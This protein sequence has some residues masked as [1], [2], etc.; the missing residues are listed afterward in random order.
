MKPQNHSHILGEVLTGAGE[1]R[2]EMGS[3]ISIPTKAFS[4]HRVPDD[5]AGERE[6]GMRQFL[7]PM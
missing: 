3:A 7:P 6:R 2:V 1:S 5:L 4:S